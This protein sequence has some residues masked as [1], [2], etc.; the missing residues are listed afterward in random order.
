MSSE[1]IYDAIPDFGLFYDEVPIYSTR[2][3][4]EFYVSEADRRAP[5][6]GRVLD[7]GCG[8]GRLLLPLARAG[9]HVIGV[10]HSSAMLD[11]CREKLSEESAEVR[12]RVSLQEGDVRDLNLP[13]SE[14]PVPFAMA[15]FRVFQHLITV[16]DQ[17]RA[18]A[19]VKRHLA[20]RGY[21]AFDVFNPNFGLMTADRSAEAEDTPE[22]PV[23]DGR[24]FRRAA[25]VIRIRWV[26]QVSEI[27]L[28]Y[29]VRDADKVSRFVQAFDMRWYTPTEL[30]HLLARAGFAV[31]AIYGSFDRNPLTDASNE[32]LVV[33]RTA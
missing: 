11:R 15:P 3:D 2:Q 1:R 14:T 10:D 30:E 5:N 27:E 20:P 7:L 24:F 23:G 32:I 33:A 26:E 22:R 8:T 25:R 13:G 12:A 6:R 31:E 21:F 29:Y 16:D 17:L 19:A 9:H 4:V 28:I 18:L